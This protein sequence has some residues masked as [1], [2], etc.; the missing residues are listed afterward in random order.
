MTTRQEHFRA[1]FGNY[2]HMFEE[3]SVKGANMRDVAPLE[4]DPWTSREVAALV[5]AVA[6]EVPES[7]GL[8]A[9]A[10]A[11]RGGSDGG[12]GK[13]FLRHPFFLRIILDLAAEGGSPAGTRADLIRQWVWRKLTRDLKTSR[14]TPVPVVDRNA[15]IEQMEAIMT[16]VAGAMVKE[17]AGE[18]RML[19]TIAS[20]AVI[21]TCEQ[22]FETRID[23]ASAI[24]VTLLLPTSIRHRGSFP[25]RFS[26]RAF[27]EYFLARHLV[28]TRI[29][30]AGYPHEVQAFG[31]E[32]RC[33]DPS[34]I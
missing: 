28:E 9:L 34:G 5:D 19:D 6:E 4:L 18:Y 21:Q 31:R 30:T 15:F 16:A 12:W 27:Q 23:L 20:E 2:D 11:G 8:V 17:V 13:E 14:S 32:L 24:S 33:E 3:L 26:H 1:T 7:E 10:Q 22:V 25:I 29:D